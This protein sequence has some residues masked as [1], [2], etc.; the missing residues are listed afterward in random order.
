MVG[1]RAEF[2]R[3]PTKK[4]GQFESNVARK[5]HLTASNKKLRGVENNQRSKETK[6]ACDPCSKWIIDNH[7]KIT[8]GDLE[9]LINK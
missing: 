9:K 5:F 1:L 2:R 4:H 6:S 8:R 3:E 7:Q